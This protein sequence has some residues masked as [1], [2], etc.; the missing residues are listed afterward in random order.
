MMG[1]EILKVRQVAIMFDVTD[2]T[3]RRWFYRKKFPN[4][5]ST[6]GNHLRIPRDDAERLKKRLEKSAMVVGVF[7]RHS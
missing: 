2:E 7:R 3:V 1:Q 5:W 4:A 6:A